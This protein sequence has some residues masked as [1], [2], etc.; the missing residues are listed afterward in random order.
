MNLSLNAEQQKQAERR[1]R[2]LDAQPRFCELVDRKL[3][4]RRTEASIASTHGH[5]I[6]APRLHNEVGRYRGACPR[7]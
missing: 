3:K 4:E 5:I 7:A 6:G 2:A 1:L